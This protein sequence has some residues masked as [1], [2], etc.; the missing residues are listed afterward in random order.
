MAGKGIGGLNDAEN[1]LAK[2]DSFL[3][4][5]LCGRGFQKAGQSLVSWCS[6]VGL[7][8]CF[9]PLDFII[10]KGFIL[11]DEAEADFF[12]DVLAAR[13]FPNGIG[14]YGFQPKPIKGIFYG[15]G[16]GARSVALPFY[17]IILK[18][19]AENAGAV[20]LIDLFE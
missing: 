13:V 17:G 6:F 4:A 1:E 16:F 7:F 11:A 14:V 9:R 3:P 20:F 18:M 8:F 19:N 12:Q 10:P 2:K 15:K 5:G